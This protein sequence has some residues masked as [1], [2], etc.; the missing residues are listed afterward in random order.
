MKIFLLLGISGEL[1][2]YVHAT[3]LDEGVN[4][5]ISYSI[6]SHLP[7]SIDNN[8]GMISTN[9]ELDYEDVKV[10]FL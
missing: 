3:D 2:G 7:F 5:M 6:P 4:A 8:T 9:T 10:R 1:V